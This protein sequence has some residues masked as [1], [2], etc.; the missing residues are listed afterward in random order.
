[1]PNKPVTV[2]VMCKVRPGMEERTREYFTAL[3]PASRAEEGCIDYE[4]QQAVDDP[5]LF[6]LYMNWRDEETFQ[7]HVQAPLVKQFDDQLAQEMLAEPY[8]LQRWQQLG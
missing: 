8:V 4:W 5:R 6:L 1:M 2:T 7:R 3:I